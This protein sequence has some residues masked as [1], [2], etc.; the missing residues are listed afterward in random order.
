L[1]FV[2]PCSDEI[3]LEAVIEFAY[4]RFFSAIVAEEG[5]VH[6]VGSTT[7]RQLSVPV[8]HYVSVASR[9]RRNV[10]QDPTNVLQNTARLAVGFTSLEIGHALFAHICSAQTKIYIR[11]GAPKVIHTTS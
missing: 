11:L 10:V 9:S 7:R 2:E 1:V 5:I 8:L 3:A 4:L 6:Q